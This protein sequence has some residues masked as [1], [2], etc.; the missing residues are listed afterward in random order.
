MSQEAD[1][2]MYVLRNRGG[3]YLGPHDLD[4][5]I[6]L[7]DW[8]RE[9]KLANGGKWLLGGDRNMVLYPEDSAGPTA[10][11]KGGPLAA[12]RSLDQRMDLVDLYHLA[13][14]RED[15]RLTRQVIRSERLDQARL[16]RIYANRKGQWI[17]IIF[18]M[19]HD[20]SEAAS[21]HIHD[22]VLVDL[23]LRR[24]KGRRIRKAAYLK[25]DV[26]TI[27]KPG[28]KERLREV[29]EE[30]WSLSPD[31]IVA[32]DLAWGRIRQEFK[33]FRKL[34]REQSSTLEQ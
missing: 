34:D 27:R 11:L 5:K 23:Q 16:D 6:K 26:D 19:K 10:L 4:E 7:L 12:W 18:R 32:W 17:P 31:P 20:E 3:K 2:S 14:A 13:A 30:G 28:R 21:D 33:I 25:M 9:S 29:W 24:K 15:L 1:F 22:I 8:I